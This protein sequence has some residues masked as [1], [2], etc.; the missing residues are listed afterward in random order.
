M[1]KKE[2]TLYARD[3]KEDLI[4][5]EVGLIINEND[6]RQLEYENETVMITPMTRGEI[7]KL[8]SDMKKFS[9]EEDENKVK[10]YDAEMIVNHLHKPSYTLEEVKFL[11]PWFA[12]MFTDTIMY[13]SGLD[14]NS[15][16][17]KKAIESKEDEFA[18]N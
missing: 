11:K 3:D 17:R 10:D 16:S 18:K 7:K 8:L 4:P 9:D 15:K 6:E 12:K 2:T 13:E 5:I 14:V 1:I